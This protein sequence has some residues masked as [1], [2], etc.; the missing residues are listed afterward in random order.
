LNASS[1]TIDEMLPNVDEVEIQNEALESDPHI[2]S[3]Q[4]INESIVEIEETKVS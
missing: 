1:R 3:P 2:Y 4:V